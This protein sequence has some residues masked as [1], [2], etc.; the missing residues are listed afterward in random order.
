MQ[1]N[2]LNN[3]SKVQAVIVNNVWLTVITISLIVACAFQIPCQSTVVPKK[4][5][6]AQ[7]KQYCHACL[8]PILMCVL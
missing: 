1:L 6:I 2:F 8:G 3:W 5:P 7:P 4:D